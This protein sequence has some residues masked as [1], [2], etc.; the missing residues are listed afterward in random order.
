M[1]T[2]IHKI[3]GKASRV[4][5][6]AFQTQCLTYMHLRS[7]LLSEHN[8][9]NDVVDTLESKIKATEEEIDAAEKLLE[10]K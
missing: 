4:D 6:M 8:K 9:I 1:K 2:Y 3:T 5:L 10:V 7:F